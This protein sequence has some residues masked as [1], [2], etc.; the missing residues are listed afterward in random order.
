MAQVK[1]PI[2]Y[3]RDVYFSPEIKAVF[4]SRY[5]RLRYTFNASSIIADRNL[6]RPGFLIL[7]PQNVVEVGCDDEMR[8]HNLVVEI[9]LGPDKRL[10]MAL[11]C[12][13]LQQGLARVR[14]VWVYVGKQYRLASVRYEADPETTD[15]KTQVILRSDFRNDFSTQL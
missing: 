15:E 12:N 5:V 14:T 9:P 2:L 3:H 7:T 1:D 4:A 13:K 6:P 8:I 10:Y 11:A